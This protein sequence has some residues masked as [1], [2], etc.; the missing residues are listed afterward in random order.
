VYESLFS[1]IRVKKQK[2]SYKKTADKSGL[3]L[4]AWIKKVL[5]DE[6]KNK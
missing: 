1:P 3:S 5:D 4:S 2:R 6:I